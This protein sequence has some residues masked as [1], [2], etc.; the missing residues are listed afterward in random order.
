MFSD[1]A[2]KLEGEMIVE[3]SIPV[4]HKPVSSMFWYRMIQ[5]QPPPVEV[6][7]QEHTWDW[8]VP[9]RALLGGKLSHTHVRIGGPGRAREPEIRTLMISTG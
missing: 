2:G 8:K 4:N 5:M 1:I 3:E 7:S 9:V 6:K